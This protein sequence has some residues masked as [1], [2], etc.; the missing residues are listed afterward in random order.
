MARALTG[1]C[2]CR[3]ARDKTKIRP[4]LGIETG[5]AVFGMRGRA[6]AC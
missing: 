3:G 6:Q 4:P 5:A 2:A 1:P